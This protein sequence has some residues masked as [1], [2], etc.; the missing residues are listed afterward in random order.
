MFLKALKKYG[1]NWELIQKKIKTRN[2]SQIKSRA[3]KLLSSVTDDD[4]ESLFGS[5]PH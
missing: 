5:D 2:L 1:K 3:Y 4:V